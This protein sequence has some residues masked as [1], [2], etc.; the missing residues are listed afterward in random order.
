MIKKEDTGEWTDLEALKS[1]AEEAYNALNGIL[2]KQ[3]DE[4]WES[5]VETQGIW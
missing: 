4:D 1:I 2:E 3:T 5:T